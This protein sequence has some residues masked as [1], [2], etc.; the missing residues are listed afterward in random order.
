M[1]FSLDRAT[2]D[3]LQQTAERLRKP[4]SEVVREA[5]AQYAERVGRLSERERRELLH[6]FD[7][8]VTAI[9]ARPLT[10]VEAEL[11]AV[12]RARR[13]GGRAGARER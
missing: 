1:T 9:P 2:S 6:S 8:L 5:I 13:A 11:T 7:R 3:R 4:K 12:R 10:E